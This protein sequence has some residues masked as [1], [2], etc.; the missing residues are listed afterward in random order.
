[1]LSNNVLLYILQT[2]L[3]YLCILSL[4]SFAVPVC[5]NCLT[6]N[7]ATSFKSY[8]MRQTR[9]KDDTIEVTYSLLIM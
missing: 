2:Y 1:M 7:I 5:S 6:C 4:F 8:M 9:Q 3:L